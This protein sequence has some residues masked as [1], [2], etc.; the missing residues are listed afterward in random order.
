MSRSR[1]EDAYSI[2]C[3]E[4]LS[5]KFFKD[6]GGRTGSRLWNHYQHSQ[7]RSRSNGYVGVSINFD[8]FNKRVLIFDSAMPPQIIREFDNYIA[9]TPAEPR[10]AT[11]DDIAQIVAF[12]C[13]EG[14]RW[15][16]GSVTCANGGAVFV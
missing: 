4:G 3:F 16:T 10:V 9:Q 11:V 7:S 1:L 14:S 13:E 6:L 15:V 12:L 8:A 5:R 2:W